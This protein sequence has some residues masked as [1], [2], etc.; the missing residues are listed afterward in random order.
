MT[1]SAVWEGLLRGAIGQQR[2]IPLRYHDFVLALDVLFI[3]GAIEVRDGLL[4]RP[5][6]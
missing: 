6:A 2:H 5:A 1:A 3:L 4:H